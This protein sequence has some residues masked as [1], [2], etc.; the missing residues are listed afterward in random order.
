M[1]ILLVCRRLFRTSVSTGLV[2]GGLFG[3]FARRLSERLWTHRDPLSVAGHHQ[4]RLGCGGVVRRLAPQT[5]RVVV[6][7]VLSRSRHQ[8]FGLPL[9]D[10]AA[11]GRIH[12]R[13]RLLPR[14]HPRL[15]RDQPPK[16]E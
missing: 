3:L 12:P 9:R 11:G 16:P 2:S 6:V 5:L 13:H 10:V 1:A 14:L 8:L 4:Q 7:E 15:L